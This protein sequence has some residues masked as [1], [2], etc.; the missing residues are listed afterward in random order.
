MFC[1]Q[2]LV[3]STVSTKTPSVGESGEL[4]TCYLPKLGVP[5]FVARLP[6]IS[7]NVSAG[8]SGKGSV[9]FLESD[10]GVMKCAV[11]NLYCGFENPL[12]RSV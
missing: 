11:T 12:L 8:R 5:D 1:S 3:T 2:A 9:R 10:S 7:S 4:P 6:E